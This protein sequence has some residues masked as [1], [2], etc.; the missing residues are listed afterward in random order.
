MTAAVD[1][2]K[3]VGAR[4]TKRIV[5]FKVGLV[6]LSLSAA[7]EHVLFVMVGGLVAFFRLNLATGRRCKEKI[8]NF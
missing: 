7:E 3:R 8:S 1:K 6:L 2:V 4:D 5:L